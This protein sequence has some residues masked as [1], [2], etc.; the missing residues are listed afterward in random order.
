MA[1]LDSWLI[2]RSLSGITCEAFNASISIE[3][4]ATGDAPLDVHTVLALHD[5]VSNLPVSTTPRSLTASVVGAWYN[6]YYNRVHIIPNTIDAGNILT[7]K[8]Y[9]VEVWSAYSSP[10]LLSDIT[11]IDTDGTSLIGTT[12]PIYFAAT[13]SKIYTAEIT[14]NGPIDLNARY[15][16]VFEDESVSLGITGKRAVLWPF[17]PDVGFIEK[18]KWKTDVIT[19]VNAEQRIANRLAP[20]QSFDQS[21]LLD[22]QQFSRAKAIASQWGDKVYGVP[23]WSEMTYLVNGLT[24]GQTVISF[25]TSFA[26]YRQG[27]YALIWESDKKFSIVEITE[28]LSNQITI[29]TPLE[30]NF[31]RCYVLPTR[32]GRAFD[33]V[34]FSR[35]GNT[36][37]FAKAMFDITDNIDLA[38][39]GSF[40]T[41][42]SKPV[43][44]DRSIVIGDIAEKMYRVT[45]YFDNGQGPIE[46]E[47]SKNWSTFQQTISFAKKSPE[48]I[49]KLRQWLHARRGRQKSFW[50]P[51]WNKDLVILDNV[52]ADSTSLVVSAIGYPLYYTTKDIMIVLKNGNRIFAR[53]IA[54]QDASEGEELL[55][56]S[57]VIGTAF[58]ASDVNFV[59][60]LSH[61]R[62]DTDEVSFTH[63]YKGLVKTSINVTE[64]PE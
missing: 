32:F 20:R 19:A 23:V 59:S 40:V 3:F 63:D 28:L 12:Y 58:N 61:V 1:V 52:A 5:V 42:R 34:S 45:E 37:I 10:K 44:T 35:S 50:L 29:R 8:Q 47:A 4:W 56:L 6:D 31:G 41:Y 17:V 62:L 57:A 48:D 30:S 39:E 27:G 64:T 24:I 11:E 22:Q 9:P 18:M 21:F 16:F 38:N 53:I 2:D 36:N 54:G 15:T 7:T 55:V 46:V 25:D 51:S 26:D 43:L 60:F 13:E 14:Q 33:G 49:W